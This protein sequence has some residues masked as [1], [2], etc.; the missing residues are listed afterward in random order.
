MGN[1]AEDLRLFCGLILVL[2]KKCGGDIIRSGSD[3]VALEYQR[4]GRNKATLINKAYIESGEYRRKFDSITDNSAVNKALY[5]CTKAALKHRSGTVYEDMYWIDGDTGKVVLSV[6]N[7][8]DE[9]AIVYT[10]KIKKAIRNCSNI[11]TIHT[12]PSSMPP[13]ID[14]FNSCFGNGYKMGIVACH[15]GRLFKYTSGQPVS[16]PLYNLYV[17]DYLGSGCTEFDAQIKTLQ[18]LKGNHMIDFEEV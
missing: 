12:H 7:S 4:Y 8:T 17:G 14:D 13:S 3:A 1:S 18:K 6:I 2:T 15:N 11:I 5:D 10:E 9:R 16:K